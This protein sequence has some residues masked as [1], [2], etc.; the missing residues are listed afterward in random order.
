M[1]ENEIYQ[2][3]KSS[4][5]NIAVCKISFENQLYED[6]YFPIA[7][8]HD[9]F[10]GILE[11]DF[12]LDGFSIRKIYDITNV[13]AIRGTYLKIHQ[14]EGNLSRITRPPISLESWKSVF[15][16]IS[17]SNEIVS[18]EGYLPEGDDFE[19]FFIIGKVL[20]VGEQGI[21]FRTFD[22]GGNWA[23]KPMTLPYFAITN[24]S[25]GNSYTTTYA[26]YVK[27]YPEIKINA[28]NRPN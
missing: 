10:L 25:F 28:F 1:D 19:K 13:E 17:S 9:L 8:S 7:F 15:R 14:S 11:R 20:A 22:G 24:V 12:V 5:N 18:I 2:T 21:R 27:E 3:L 23:E 4:I 16:F 26:K 6:F